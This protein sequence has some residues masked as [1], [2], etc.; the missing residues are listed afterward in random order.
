VAQ[1]TRPISTKPRAIALGAGITKGG[2]GT[3]RQASS[4][5]GSRRRRPAPARRGR[6]GAAARRT[7][8]AGPA[9]GPGG[10][11][12]RGRRLGGG[13][14]P[15]SRPTGRAPP[16]PARSV[17]GGTTALMRAPARL[18]SCPRNVGRRLVEARMRERVHRARTRQA[19]VDDLADAAPAPGHRDDA[20]GEQQRL[21]DGV[22]D[23]RRGLGPLGPMRSSSKLV[24]S[25][26]S[27]SSAR[28]ARPCGGCPDRAAAH[29]RCPPA[30]AC[31]PSSSSRRRCAK[32]DSP[33][34]REE[35][36][37][38]RRVRGRHRAGLVA[39]GEEE[40]LPSTSCQGG[41]RRG[42]WNT[43][44]V[45]SR[46]STTGIECSLD[47]GRRS[48][49]AAPRPAAAASTC[50]SPRGRATATNSWRAR[51]S[52]R[53]SSATTS[54]PL[55]G[56]ADEALGRRARSVRAGRHDRPG[57]TTGR[58]APSLTSA[59]KPVSIAAAGSILSSGR[60]IDFDTH[61]Q[62]LATREGSKRPKPSFCVT[63]LTISEREASNCA[64]ATATSTSGT[65]DFSAS[66]AAA[67]GLASAA[68]LAFADRKC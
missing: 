27:A 28:T 12:R 5:R 1:D 37:G 60:L 22:G 43:M 58:P 33:T 38:A 8:P 34:R 31:R 56:G 48:A 35:L 42:R 25:R 46:G 29:A 45:S 24:S 10:R 26:V 41:P 13:A 63:A 16:S 53:S 9:G 62:V 64:V 66:A 23:E 39:R 11:R 3:S 19:D 59:R 30:A 6:P 15:R 44:P 61:S 7:G 57:G 4:R 65:I 49:P 54:R 40:T 32:S 51:S 47:V 36:A 14:P 17:A 50:R 20:I 21:G 18:N 68:S 67:F 2:I 55:A 52:D